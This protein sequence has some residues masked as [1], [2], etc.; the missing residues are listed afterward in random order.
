M[1]FGQ[2]VKSTVMVIPSVEASQTGVNI[3]NIGA[4]I[5][6]SEKVQDSLF[7]QLYL[8]NDPLKKYETIKLVHTEHDMFVGSLKS[9]GANIGDFIYYQGFRGPIKIWEVKYPEN[10][11]E[12]EEFLRTDGKYGEFDDLLFR[13]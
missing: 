1:D 13:K 5:Y 7:A 11:V 4:I 8:M 6:L 9:Q 10:V 3:N 12:R 2:G